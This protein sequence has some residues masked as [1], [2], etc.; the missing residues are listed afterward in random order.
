MH[1]Y[2][3]APPSIHERKVKPWWWGL[4]VRLYP[5]LADLHW[6]RRWMGGRWELRDCRLINVGDVWL[7]NPEGRD[8]EYWMTGYIHPTRELTQKVIAVEEWPKR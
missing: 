8:I 2:R 7:H 6:F 3:E 1:P 5:Y 4:A